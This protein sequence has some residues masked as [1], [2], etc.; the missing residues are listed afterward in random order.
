[1]EA[2][3]KPPVDVPLRVTAGKK[4]GSTAEAQLFNTV[5]VVLE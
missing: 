3:A 5:T 4:A 1:L 2:R